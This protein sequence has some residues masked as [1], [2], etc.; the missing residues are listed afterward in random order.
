M[1]RTAK[2]NYT[3]EFSINDVMNELTFISCRSFMWRMID[4]N[5]LHRSMERLLS[6]PPG[7]LGYVQKCIAWSFKCY[8]NDGD[9]LSPSIRRRKLGSSLTSN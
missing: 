9:L 7:N 4:G 1:M 8:R 3:R 5:L 2:V 6:M